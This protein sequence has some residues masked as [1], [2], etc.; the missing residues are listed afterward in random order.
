MCVITVTVADLEGLTGVAPPPPLLNIVNK[1]DKF[2]LFW[3]FNQ[4]PLLKRYKLGSQPKLFKKSSGSTTWLDKFIDVF[5][6]DTP[7]W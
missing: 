5:V 2:L 1:N 7:V 3:N 4:P 6:N